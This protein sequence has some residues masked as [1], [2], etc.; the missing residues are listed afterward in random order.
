MASIKKVDVKDNRDLFDDKVLMAVNFIKENYDIRIPIQDPSKIQITCK[1]KNLYTYPPTF[2]DLYLHLISANHNISKSILS[3]IIR[4]PNKIQPVNPIKEYFDKIRGKYAGVSHIDILCSHLEPRSFEYNT[5]EFYRNRT[6]KLIK[7]WLVACVACWVGGVPND[8][9]LGFIQRNGGS[10]KTHLTRFL[11]PDELSDFYIQSSKDDKK[12]DIEDSYTRYM[13]VNYEELEGLNKS[14][15]NTFKSAQ[16]AEFIVTKLRYE[17]FPTRKQRIGCGMFST[18]FNE[19]NGGFIHPYFGSDTRRF[20][21]IEITDINQS[22]SNI[23]DIDQVWAEALMLFE[24]SEFDYKFRKPDYEDFNLYNTRYKFETEAMKYVQLYV[25][26]PDNPS[27]CEKLN[28]TQILQEL[29]RRKK[30]R[31]SDMEKITP[32]K[33]G[34]ALTL[35]GYKQ[36]PHRQPGSVNPLKVYE[37]KFLE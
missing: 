17:E 37:I 5:P 23:V 11:L 30:I 36:Y 28:A 22:Y 4:S 15:I 35:L 12:F 3:M 13:I 19:E 31:S 7:K 33:V 16:S 27:E 9:A 6:D 34:Q 8:V 32:Q 21:C 25:G 10:G 29:I 18:N 26:H 24:S 2:E 20:G 14:S 1:H